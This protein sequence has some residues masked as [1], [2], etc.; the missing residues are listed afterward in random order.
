MKRCLSTGN[1][2]SASSA[3]DDPFVVTV[4]KKARKQRQATK[5]TLTSATQPNIDTST[6]DVSLSQ[7]DIDM[8]ISSVA[9]PKISHES[10]FSVEKRDSDSEC[11]SL[12]AEINSLNAV[13]TQLNTKVEFLLSYLGLKDDNQ[14]NHS[15][16]QSVPVPQSSPS[17]TTIRGPQTSTMTYASAACAKSG[18]QLSS[19]LRQA[20]VSAV[21]ED[22][23]SKSTR[24]NN[25]IVTGLPK[26]ESKDD[27]ESFL[28]MIEYEFNIK[29]TVKY[30]RRL[31]KAMANKTQNLLVALGSPEDVKIILS[32]A[33]Q[34][35]SSQND[36]IRANVFVNADLTKAEA[37]VAYQDRCRRRQQREER[38]T[39]QRQQQQ[40][41]QQ[42][43]S[44][45]NA[46]LFVSVSNS[47]LNATVSAF[48]PS[49][50][51]IPTTIGP[52]SSL[53][54]PLPNDSVA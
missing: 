27:K 47:Q 49:A 23:H 8:I 41:Q 40:Q 11:N 46:P 32:G 2:N 44:N 33:K 1:V 45:G 35:R 17:T 21:Y 53:Q 7:T 37:A 54:L 16:E 48:Q 28:E 38:S 20:V 15:Q 30:C 51:T 50:Q 22:L 34:L 6:N 52:T 26:L 12:R 29:P 4:N 18:T 10:G 39:K 31:G 3:T 19:Q 13:I 36:F 24:A 43:G 9:T 5:R 14:I 42:L 25:I